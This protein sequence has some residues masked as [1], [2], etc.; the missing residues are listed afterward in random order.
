MKNLHNALKVRYGD[1]FTLA[2]VR[3]LD[4]AYR[5]ETITFDEIKKKIESKNVEDVI[6]FAWNHKFLIPMAFLRS[7]EWD[8]R[9]LIM[10]P[11]EVY[12]MPNISRY[13][14]KIAADTGTW[15]IGGAVAYLYKDMGEPFWEK[16]PDLVEG[17]TTNSVNFIIS[18]ASINA[19][20]IKAG[21]NNKTGAMIAILKGGGVISPK[22]AAIGPV[23]KSG[24]PI[25]EVNP[26]VYYI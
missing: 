5:R 7:G 11:C 9:I 21:I 13:L 18:A 20:C 23:V 6:L 12:E 16:M 1:D 3:L 8:D 19:A 4:M 2:L 17:I 25:Y 10:E 15:D 14:L 26:C 24:V 22:L